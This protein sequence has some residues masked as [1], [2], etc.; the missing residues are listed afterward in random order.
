MHYRLNQF[1][2]VEM[3][4]IKINY[5]EEECIVLYPCTENTCHMINEALYQ[6]HNM[7]STPCYYKVLCGIQRQLWLL[8]VEILDVHI[9]PN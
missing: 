5:M 3:C 4:P 2:E 9:A 8:T 1:V 7:Q 6:F